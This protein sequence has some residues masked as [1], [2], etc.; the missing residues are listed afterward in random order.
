MSVKVEFLRGTAKTKKRPVKSD[1]SGKDAKGECIS[2]KNNSSWGTIN[3]S[4]KI[5]IIA[6]T[7]CTLCALQES[8]NLDDLPKVKVFNK[9]C[10]IKKKGAGEKEK[11]LTRIRNEKPNDCLKT[12][13]H[14]YNTSGN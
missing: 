11:V 3:I 10:V 6:I 2:C 9:K 8:N 13:L 1:R 7:C 4:L 5:C 12:Y 14:C